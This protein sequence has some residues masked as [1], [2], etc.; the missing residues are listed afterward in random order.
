LIE[1]W[2]Q[3]TEWVL[4]HTDADQNDRTSYHWVATRCLQQIIG[5]PANNQSLPPGRDTTAWIEYL[6]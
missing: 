1:D 2:V 4:L 6:T 5:K 3:L